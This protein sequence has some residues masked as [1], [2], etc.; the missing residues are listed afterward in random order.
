MSTSKDSGPAKK[1]RTAKAKPTTD[2]AARSSAGSRRVKATAASI[3]LTPEERW[4]MIAVAAYHK[5][6]KRGFAPG[7][8]DK[9]WFEAEKVVDAL[10]GSR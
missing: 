6:E 1:K 4:R 7:N 9:D 3:E 2:G 10:L 8:A 5:A